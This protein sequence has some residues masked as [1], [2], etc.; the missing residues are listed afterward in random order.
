MDADGALQKHHLAISGQIFLVDGGAVFWSSKKQELVTLSTTEAEY[1]AA[2]HAAK[3]IIWLQCFIGEVFRPLA[4]LTTLYSNSQTAITLTCDRNYYAHM[5]HIDV[6]YHYI[7]YIIED[8]SIQLIYCPTDEQTADTLTKALPS[9][10][11]KHFTVAMGLV[12]A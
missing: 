1:I 2:T 8:G 9:A 4:E 11:V 3:K 12:A 10:K 7:H 6:C 5:K